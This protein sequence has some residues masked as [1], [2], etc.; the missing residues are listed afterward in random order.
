[1]DL[2]KEREAQETETCA[3]LSGDFLQQ[4]TSI[5]Q[6]GSQP[7]K[8]ILIFSLTSLSNFTLKINEQ[9]IF[10]ATSRIELQWLRNCIVP[11]VPTIPII[12]R[13]DDPN[14]TTPYQTCFFVMYIKFLNYNLGQ[15]MVLF[16]KLVVVFKSFELYLSK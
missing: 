13:W 1:M 6:Q 8:L 10:I 7:D 5:S 12:H 11:T 9:M 4:V 14:I 16:W 3:L 15:S 2:S